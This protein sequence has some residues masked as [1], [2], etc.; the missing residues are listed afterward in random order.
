MF[1]CLGRTVV[2]I[3]F[4]VLLAL[5]AA[6][7][8]TRDYWLG[9]APPPAT[10]AE[11]SE[12]GSVT[13]E[14]ADKAKQSLLAL[15]TGGGPVYVNLSAPELLSY[16]LASFRPVLPQ[17]ATDLQARVAGDLV[18]VK[19]VV[20]IADLGGTKV[21]G[22]LAGLLPSRDTIEVGGS[23]EAIRTGLGQL[24]VK[25]LRAGKLTVPPRLVPR[26]LEQ[27]RR[28]RLPEGI[29]ADALPIVLPANVGDVRIRNGKITLYRSAP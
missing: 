13:P 10:A 11:T 5:G 28:G 27:L 19:G 29:A 23:L 1:G 20:S 26:L 21:L 18:Y 9:S 8:F 7:W 14:R 12:W 3:V 6:A 22:P 17:S 25:T 15:G 24:H 4:I 16:A 2:A